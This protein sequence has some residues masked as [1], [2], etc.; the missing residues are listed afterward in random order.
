MKLRTATIILFI[1]PSWMVCAPLAAQESVHQVHEVMDLPVKLD[2]GGSLDCTLEFHEQWTIRV[3]GSS[4]SKEVSSF[5]YSCA[6]STR[7]LFPAEGKLRVRDISYEFSF[8][9]PRGEVMRELQEGIIT[10]IN[11]MHP[12]PGV[13]QAEKQ[14]LSVHFHEDWILDG[15][16]Q[17]IQKKVT[18]ITPVI[19]Q[20][21]QT[22]DGEPVLDG[23]TGYP[24]YFKLTLDRIPLRQP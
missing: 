23:D 14:L 13:Y 4:I 10:L 20:I 9:D 7:S 12:L 18:G 17:D 3:H 2:P 21:R 11:S 1:L 19:W 22:V 8:L 6:D 15:E 24:V 5:R 16:Q